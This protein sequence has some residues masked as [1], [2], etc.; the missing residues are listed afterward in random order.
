MTEIFVRSETLAGT[1]EENN[2]S[3]KP[4]IAMDNLSI[5]QNGVRL[6]A[7]A[8]IPG[9]SVFSNIS[10]VQFFVNGVTI[11]AVSG[12][13]SF[14]SSGDQEYVFYWKPET[15]GIYTFYAMAVGDTFDD[16]DNYKISEPFQFEVT[17][18]HIKAFADENTPP[19]ISLITPGT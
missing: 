17:E 16:G 9:S 8:G 7:I 13:N 1:L 12:P 3:Q 6:R 11:D 15:A 10:R 4:Y 19:T 18:D 5:D 2:L 14:L